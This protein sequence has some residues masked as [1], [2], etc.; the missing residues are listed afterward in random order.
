MTLLTLCVAGIIFGFKNFFNKIEDL[1]ILTNIHVDAKEGDQLG[2]VYKDFDV[3]V[4][5]F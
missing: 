3:I 2:W 4:R 1:S 5:S